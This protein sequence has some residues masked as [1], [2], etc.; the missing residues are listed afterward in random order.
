MNF[1]PGLKDTVAGVVSTSEV[2]PTTVINGKTTVTTAG[3]NVQ[4]TTNSC[5]SIVIK[6]LVANTGSIFVGNATVSSANGFVLASGDT[7]ALD[8]NNTNVVYIDSSVNGEGVSF[9][10]IN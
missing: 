10:A 9:L 8:I 6:A 1:S 3:T 4:L 5:K 7:V 2:A